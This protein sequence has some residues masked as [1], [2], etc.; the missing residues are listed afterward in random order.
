M[1]PPYGLVTPRLIAAFIVLLGN[2]ANHPY[3][4]YGTF[5]VFSFLHLLIFT[6]FAIVL[7]QRLCAG[8]LLI[9]QMELARHTDGEG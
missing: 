8:S 1:L 6:T 5:V 7:L 2:G 4:L 9:M 3:T